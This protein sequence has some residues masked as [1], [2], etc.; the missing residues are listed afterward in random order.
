MGEAQTP[1]PTTKP[2]P[3][4]PASSTHPNKTLAKSNSPDWL[5]GSHDFHILASLHLLFL[6]SILPDTHLTAPGWHT[7]IHPIRPIL[8][9]APSVKPSLTTTP[10]WLIA[11]PQC[12]QSTLNFPGVLKLLSGSNEQVDRQ[13]YIQCMWI[14]H[15]L[16]AGNKGWEKSFQWCVCPLGVDMR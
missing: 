13:M 12:L 4:S 14:Q 15:L 7:H 9:H 16:P 11:D 5:Q 2:F 8:S 1:W 6:P 3:T 10:R